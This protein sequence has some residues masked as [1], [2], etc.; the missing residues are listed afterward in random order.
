MNNE[1]LLD[2]STHQANGALVT[3]AALQKLRK[4][5]SSAIVFAVFIC[6]TTLF[7]IISNISQIV[8]QSILDVGSSIPKFYRLMNFY[9]LFLNLCQILVVVMLFRYISKARS[10]ASTNPPYSGEQTFGALNSL[11][12]WMTINSALL[13]LSFIL[14]RLG[15]LVSKLE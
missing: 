10:F 13:L 5:N 6:L 3:E 14:Y 15:P 4:A 1:H 8:S 12:F 9:H 7:G 2:D 11:F